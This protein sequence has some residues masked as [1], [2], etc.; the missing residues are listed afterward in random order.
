MDSDCPDDYFLFGGQLISK[1]PYYEYGIES[2]NE[3]C[4]QREKQRKD[5]RIKIE[6][7]LKIR[8]MKKM[9]EELLN[10]E[11]LDESFR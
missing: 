4:E 8:K 6:E 11:S 5:D 7:I 10:S 1:K 9:N 2:L 3:L